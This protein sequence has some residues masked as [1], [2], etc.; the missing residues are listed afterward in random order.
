MSKIDREALHRYPCTECGGCGP[1]NGPGHAYTTQP[2]KKANTYKAAGP[3]IQICGYCGQRLADHKTAILLC[4][5][6][7][8]S[9][10]C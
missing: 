4:P 5:E 3:H 1:H 7:N 9:R 8:D 2:E 6:G 10:R